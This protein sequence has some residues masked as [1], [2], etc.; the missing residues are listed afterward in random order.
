M[1][2]FK[3]GDTDIFD[4]EGAEV[5]VEGNMT[6]AISDIFSHGVIV[7]NGVF[8]GCDVGI[9][10]KPTIIEENQNDPS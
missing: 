7:R 5:D 8:K 3:E 10:M 4:F 2:I 9:G 1:R 6:N